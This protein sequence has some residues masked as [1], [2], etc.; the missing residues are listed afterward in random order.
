[1]RL[2]EDLVCS[3]DTAID[4][5]RDL[6]SAGAI[7]VGDGAV[8]Y[9][10]LLADAFGGE[11]RL[12]AGGEFSTIAAQVAKLSWPRLRD[13]S[14]DDLASL[15]PIYLRSSEAEKKRTLSALTC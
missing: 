2:S 10:P 13:A 12:S 8:V 14:S 1:M 9:E 15:S 4:M 7:V 6:G 5:I 11:L 3:L